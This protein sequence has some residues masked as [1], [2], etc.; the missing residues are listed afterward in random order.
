MLFFTRSTKKNNNKNNFQQKI[1]EENIY[2]YKIINFDNDIDLT[3]KIKNTFILNN[4]YNDLY[5]SNPS[6]IFDKDNNI[7]VNMRYIN[8]KYTEHGFKENI[9]KT[10][11][12]INSKFEISNYNN[13]NIKI[14]F[15]DKLY[16]YA[17][18]FDKNNKNIQISINSYDDN[19]KNNIVYTSFENNRIVQKNWSYVHDNVFIHSWYPIKLCS[20]NKKSNHLD[21]FKTIKTPEKFINARGNCPGILIGNYF[22]FIL[23][24][25]QKNIED[26]RII[27]N[28]LHFIVCLNKN[29]N[30]IK[31]SEYFKFKDKKVEFC[32]GMIYDKD[33][34]NI[35]FS[36]S[37]LD[38]L[39][40]ISYENFDSF[41]SSLKWYYN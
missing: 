3:K 6:I 23:H 39:S 25:V 41:E 8:Y 37:C 22:Y 28:Y 38:Y 32:L 21:L 10:W 19:L 36:Y 1:K 18:C 9:P 14:Y 7:I 20:Y 29:F 27:Y 33:N 34:N 16:Y 11:L 12:T 35:L 17:S 15:N 26:K 5:S 4:Y 2:N 40:F 13:I 24:K 31:H 30:V